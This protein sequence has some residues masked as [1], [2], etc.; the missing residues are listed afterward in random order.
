MAAYKISIPT[1]TGTPLGTYYRFS[2]TGITKASVGV[3]T[4]SQAHGL[5]DGTAI[6]ISE[7][8]GMTQV[9]Y[10]TASNNIYYVKTVSGST[11]TFQLY[12]DPDVT[13]ASNQVDTSAFST[14]TSGGYVKPAVS[15]D[16]VVDRGISRSSKQRTLTAKFGDGYEQ[17]LLDG[18]NVK[19]EDFNVAFKNRTKTEID[20]LA[21]FFDDQ[22]PKSFDLTIDTETIKVICEDYNT[23]YIQ[24]NIASLTCKLRRVYE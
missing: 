24:T 22:I 7:V 4:T 21:N 23:N 1:S 6:K 18:I 12:D 9:N 11:T 14:Y 19:K 16:F 5:T 3:V 17:R 20:N 10:T 13:D 8:V 2:I 15:A